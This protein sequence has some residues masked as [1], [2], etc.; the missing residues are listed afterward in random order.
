MYTDFI[1]TCCFLKNTNSIIMYFHII[2]IFIQRLLDRFDTITRGLFQRKWKTPADLV[3]LKNWFRIF[4]PCCW[5][6]LGKK[7][8]EIWNE[9]RVGLTEQINQIHSA[10][11]NSSPIQCA[12]PLIETELIHLLF[13][14]CFCF[15]NIFS[16]S[17]NHALIVLL[18]SD[19]LPSIEQKP[20]QIW[21]GN[22]V[23]RNRKRTLFTL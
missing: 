3:T 14:F 19:C 15:S 8:R 22:G 5:F 11:V 1:L 12:R 13:C 4:I 9:K 17:S 20:T 21:N 2:C 10:G 6:H 16:L 18:N 23:K 7:K